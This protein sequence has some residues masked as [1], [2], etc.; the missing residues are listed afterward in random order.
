MQAL[1][2]PAGDRNP[3]GHTE[4]TVLRALKGLDGFRRLSF[5]YYL[6]EASG[7]LVKTLDT[8]TAG[9]VAQNWLADI[10]RTATFTIR[11]TGG[12]DFLSDRI[13]PAVRLYLPPY[14]HDDFVE[15]PQG[16][17]LLESSR[18]TR[19]RAGVLI[20]EVQGYDQLQVYSADLLD[21]RYSLAAGTVVTTAVKTLLDTAII[22]P[23]LNLTPHAGTLPAAKE[24]EPGTSKLRVINDL[25]GMI[26]YESLSFDEGGRAVVTPYRSPG[27]RPEE[28]TYAADHEGLTLPEAEQTL[29]LFSVPNKWVLVVSEPD[30]APLIGTYTNSDPASLT[31]TV[32]RQRVITDYR[33]EQEATDATVLTAKAAR[34]AFAAS[35]VYESITFS[36]APMPIH[37]GNDMYRINLPS[38]AVNSS[39]VE[40]SW[41]MTM[42][43]GIPME[44]VARRVVPV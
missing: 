9:T 20:R 17:F 13:Q 10:K 38:L 27:E 35:Q 43:A 28:F 30:Q 41:K 2:P 29:D 7:A 15:W 14:G 21:T 36:T 32:A 1:V 3:N 23:A 5:R 19:T 24:W 16:V 39:Y 18:R 6:L 22:P 42:K 25:L 4:E 40:Q 34:L 8:V 12:I 31:S 37:S 11:E 44:H 33:T 26:N